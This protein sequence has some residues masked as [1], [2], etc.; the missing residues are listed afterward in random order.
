MIFS[1]RII[2]RHIETTRSEERGGRRHRGREEKWRIPVGVWGKMIYLVRLREVE[3]GSQSQLYK[4]THK[5]EGGLL[6]RERPYIFVDGILMYL[7]RNSGLLG[8]G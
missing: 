7:L 5:E 8:F 2:R 1:K 4:E 6:Y 3:M